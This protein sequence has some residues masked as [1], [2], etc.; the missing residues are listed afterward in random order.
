MN[1]NFKFR[2]TLFVLKDRTRSLES[3][4]LYDMMILSIDKRSRAHTT[5]LY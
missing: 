2:G 4:Q 1:F 3:P 5:I